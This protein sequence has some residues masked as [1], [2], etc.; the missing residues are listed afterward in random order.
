MSAPVV[1]LTSQKGGSGKT[2]IAMQ[3]AAGLARRGLRVG[4]VDLDP[5]ESASRWAE[6]AP[7]G[8]PF[9]ADVVRVSAGT[10][11]GRVLRAL[12]DADAVLLDCPPSI[13]HPHTL[14]AL[15]VARLAIVPV[16]PG[17]TDLWS[18]RAIERLI[19]QR[20]R[21][22][23]C[24]LPNRVTRTALAAEV[25]DVLREFE[26]PL[27][28]ATLGQRSA[29]ALSAVRGGSVYSLGRQAV[30][31]QEEVERLVSAVLTRLEDHS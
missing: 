27:L 15:D 20:D 17:P 18:T 11:L 5:Q 25:I 26:L 3:L 9:P 13:E 10:K 8:Q 28:D 6:S 14:A 19:L 16:V 1:A 31:A 24:L 29:Y 21:L 12:R 30:A 7:P 22:A 2:T 4:V 23:G